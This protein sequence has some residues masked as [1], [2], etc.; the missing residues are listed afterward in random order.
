MEEL[1]RTLGDAKCVELTKRI[2]SLWYMLDLSETRKS[3]QVT[4][5]VYEGIARDFIREFLPA[6]FRI[7]GGLIFD[8]KNKRMSPQIDGIIYS[9]VPLLELTDVVVV[10]KE[11]VKAIFEVKSYIYTPTIFGDPINKET[12]TRDPDS[13]LAYEFKRRKDFVPLGAKSILF[14]FELQSDSTNDKIIKRLKEICDIYTIVL[15]YESKTERERGKEKKT[16]NFDNSVS[17]LIEWLRNL[18]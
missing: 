11:Q 4:A 16:Y 8:V 2:E 7:K 18:S 9:G 1:Y 14:A 15:R 10:E 3:T 13:G 12:G 5:A 6:E 17:R